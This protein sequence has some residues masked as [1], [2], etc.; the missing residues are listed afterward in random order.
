MGQGR[1][2]DFATGYSLGL[3]GGVRAWMMRS[4]QSL[5]E[6]PS[7]LNS[8]RSPRSEDEP[9]PEQTN[10]FEEENRGRA[11]KGIAAQ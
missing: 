1:N 2:E 10:G 8:P 6:P 9:E 5:Q 4:R 3:I 11:R 7:Q